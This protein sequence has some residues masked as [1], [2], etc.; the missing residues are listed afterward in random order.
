MNCS[1][2][3]SSQGSDPKLT[4]QENCRYEVEWVTE[5]ACH[6]DYLESHDCKLTSKQHDISIDLTHLTH[7]CKSRHGT[8]GSSEV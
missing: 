6:R 4:A 2:Y 5:Y 8:W 1:L 3:I 7:G